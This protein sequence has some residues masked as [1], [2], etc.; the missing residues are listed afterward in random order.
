MVDVQTLLVPVYDGRQP[1]DLATYK[2]LPCCPDVAPGA[3]ILLTFTMK[4]WTNKDSMLTAGLNIQDIII[5][6]DPPDE[7]TEDAPETEPRAEESWIGVTVPSVE[8]AN[9]DAQVIM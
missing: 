5:L 4:P 7:I 8:E 3:V 2:S 6:A 1:F 9:P